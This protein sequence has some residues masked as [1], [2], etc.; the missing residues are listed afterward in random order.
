MRTRKHK[1]WY[2]GCPELVWER[3]CP[4]HKTEHEVQ[5]ESW[6]RVMERKYQATCAYCG[7]EPG[8]LCI[9]WT[10]RARKWNNAHAARGLTVAPR[11]HGPCVEA[12]AGSTWEH[13]Y[14]ENAHH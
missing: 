12:P 7:S 5:H 10:G 9:S 6:L 3:Y 14:G 11:P 13:Y 4:E 1:C 2:G 8:Y